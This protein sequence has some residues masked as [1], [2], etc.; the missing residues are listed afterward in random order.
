MNGSG[1][2]FNADGPVMSGTWFNPQTGHK[3]TVRDCFFQDGQFTVMTTEGQTLDYNTIQNY[4]QVTDEHGKAQEPDNS[5]MANK[6]QQQLPPEVAALVEEDYLIPEDNAISKG[7]GNL[8]DTN[9]GVY[10][11][12][13]ETTRAG[14]M[15]VV[16][17]D[18]QDLIM[19][20]RVLRKH[21]IP[22]FEAQLIWQCPEKQIDTLV[23][24][25]GIESSTIAQYY[26][27]KLHQEVIFN[28]IKKKLADYINENWGPKISTADTGM[29]YMDP[30]S[31][32][33]I[34]MPEEPEPINLQ[35]PKATKTPKKKKTKK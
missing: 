9:R 29:V 6:P 26:V 25:L 33:L 7:L 3:F 32:E 20:D 28:D 4:I 27:N 13:M 1:I 35:K 2:S 22:E 31:G 5:L 23:N 12:P 19:I 8:N 24:I 17:D 34:P 30:E 14:Y 16:D 10:A 21:P 18:E 15:R 11:P